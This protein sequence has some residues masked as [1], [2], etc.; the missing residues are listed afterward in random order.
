MCD[1]GY[2]IIY[3]DGTAQRYNKEITEEE[4]KSDDGLFTEEPLAE[5]KQLEAT[6]KTKIDVKEEK[7]E[8][9][10]IVAN[11][12]ATA[13][14]DDFDFLEKKVV[15]EPKTEPKIEPKIESPSEI[16]EIKDDNEFDIFST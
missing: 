11:V 15:S 14:D 1:G 10:T 16:E 9:K 2:F 8:N 3:E 13:T 5:I 12:K 6:L 4:L 7:V